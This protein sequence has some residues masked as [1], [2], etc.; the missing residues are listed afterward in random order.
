VTEAGTAL[1]GGAG[2]GTSDVG[3]AV[4]VGLNGNAVVVGTTTSPDF[5]VTDGSTL[6]GLSDA[7]LLNYGF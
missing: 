3:M 6:N 7:F 1:V 5:P 2:P 4:A